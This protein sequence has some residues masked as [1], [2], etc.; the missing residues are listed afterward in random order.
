MTPEQMEAAKRA[1]ADQN[2]QEIRKRILLKQYRADQERAQRWRLPFRMIRRREFIRGEVPPNDF[3]PHV[4]NVGRDGAGNPYT[5]EDAERIDHDA[6]IFY[7]TRILAANESNLLE[8]TAGDWT[9]ETV[10]P[11]QA[12]W[13]RQT[14]LDRIQDYLAHPK[15]YDTKPHPMPEHPEKIYFMLEG[16]ADADS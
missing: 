14:Y 4:S 3:Y 12:E 2:S 16:M 15:Q 5:I 8:Y 10:T 1:L 7:F 11:D 9:G 6:A 13:Y